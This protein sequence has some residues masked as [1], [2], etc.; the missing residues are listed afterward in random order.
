MRASFML[1][2]VLESP[3]GQGYILPGARLQVGF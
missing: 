1:Q 2:Y 3:S